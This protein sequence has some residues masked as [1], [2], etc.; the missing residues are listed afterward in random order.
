MTE[1]LIGNFHVQDT[2]QYLDFGG[3]NQVSAVDI[4]KDIYTSL[5]TD[6]DD[7]KEIGKCLILAGGANLPNP[8]VGWFIEMKRINN[9]PGNSGIQI[10]YPF[11]PLDTRPLL[12][13]RFYD[14]GADT[15]GQWYSNP[16]KEPVWY[17]IGNDGGLGSTI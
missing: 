4:A 5:E 8:T 17:E 15:F 3:A 1:G 11:G 13:S 10:A 16:E 7:C 14:A 9:N 2:D 6:A 12:A